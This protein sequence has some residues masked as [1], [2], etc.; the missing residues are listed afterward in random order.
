MNINGTPTPTV[1]PTMRPLKSYSAEKLYFSINITT[2]ICEVDN[3]WTPVG[4][5]MVIN[6]DS[7]YGPA[8]TTVNALAYK[9]II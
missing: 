9:T 5:G 8:P 3:A 4:L 7:P 2:N 6:T 1:I